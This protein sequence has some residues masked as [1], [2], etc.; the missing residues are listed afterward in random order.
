[1]KIDA[2]Y[3]QPGQKMSGQT[4]SKIDDWIWNIR[5]DS[6]RWRCVHA[7]EL[8]LKLPPPRHQSQPLT[9]VLTGVKLSSNETANSCERSKYKSQI[10]EKI[11]DNV[12]WSNQ[13]LKGSSKNA[14]FAKH[15]ENRDF[16][17]ISKRMENC[18]TLHPV[19]RTHPSIQSDCHVV[20]NLV[21]A[22]IDWL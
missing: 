20:F 5:C 4:M 11:M 9:Q 19:R 7:S 18:S 6:D 2:F 8:F 1:L 15:T 17:H 16:A 10:V 3:E 13:S 14:I 21:D 22:G 12:T